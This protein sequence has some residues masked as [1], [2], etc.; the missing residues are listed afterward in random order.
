[1]R[2]AVP[3]DTE[4]PGTSHVSIADAQGN[5]VALTTTIENPF[6]RRI[7]VDGVLQFRPNPYMT[8]T[9]EAN[10]SKARPHELEYAAF[11]DAPPINSDSVFNKDNAMIGGKI[12]GAQKLV[13]PG[14]GHGA[15]LDQP[16]LFNRAVAEFL[17]GLPE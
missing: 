8:F 11:T 15:N 2:L 16:E 13:I 3:G 9:A 17:A 5:A 1:M 6:G 12:P 7:M 10:Y 4:S 14:A